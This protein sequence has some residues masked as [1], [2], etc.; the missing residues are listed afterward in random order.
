PST[1]PAGSAAR[2][3]HPG[4]PAAAGARAAP[5][6]PADPEGT[7]EEGEVDRVLL[8]QEF[9]RLLQESRLDDEA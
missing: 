6:G 4:A 5:D 3:D 2:D 1:E 9:S 8:A 7:E